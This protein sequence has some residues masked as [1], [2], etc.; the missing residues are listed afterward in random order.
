MGQPEQQQEPPGTE[1]QMEP[2]P[3][4]GEET[5]RG[6]GRLAGK[7]TVITG[8]DS[9]IGIGKEAG[10]MKPSSA[11]SPRLLPGAG[12]ARYRFKS[13][14]VAAHLYSWTPRGRSSRG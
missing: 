5:Y 2:V 14:A 9:G 10:P 1:R 6:S 4:H 13:S 3:D 12:P 8:A 7:A 11:I